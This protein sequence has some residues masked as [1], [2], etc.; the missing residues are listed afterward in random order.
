MQTQK[1][2]HVV[3]VGGGFGG[4]CGTWLGKLPYYFIMPTADRAGQ[5]GWLF[6]DK[7]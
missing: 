3:I 6:S 2:P 7:E 5:E 1:I 4:L